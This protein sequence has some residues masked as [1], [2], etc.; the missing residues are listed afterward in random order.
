VAWYAQR[1]RDQFVES[2]RRSADGHWTPRRILA[3]APLID[4]T[5]GVGMDARGDAIVVWHEEALNGGRSAIWASIRP[6]GRGWGKARPIPGAHGGPPSLAIDTR[7]DSLVTWRD[8]RGIEAVTR[9]AG[10]PW[11]KPYAV[12]VH[13]RGGPGAGDDG[14]AA[15]DNRWDA[16][17]TWQNDEGIKT[18][19]HSLLLP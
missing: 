1:G 6:A 11:R 12:S 9:P 16:F 5:V 3:E 10:G 2:A 15:I 7:G 14:L 13:E 18:A 4:E 8:E 19:W 17:A